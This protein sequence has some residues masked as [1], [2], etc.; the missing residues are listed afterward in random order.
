MT[1]RQSVNVV[2]HQPLQLLIK[3]DV[4]QFHMAE[5]IKLL[6]YVERINGLQLIIESDQA[7]FFQHH[8]DFSLTIAIGIFV[9]E[10]IKIIDIRY[11]KLVQHDDVI[12]NDGTDGYMLFTISISEEIHVAI[13][14][15]II[16]EKSHRAEVFFMEEYLINYLDKLPVRVRNA[17]KTG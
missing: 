1:L 14:I 12:V 9:Q 5:C 4:N 16:L 10:G 8:V 7:G 2:H 3:V 17:C 6:K 13:T 15:E 11:G